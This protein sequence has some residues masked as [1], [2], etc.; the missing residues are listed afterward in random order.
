MDL[1][2]WGIQSIVHQVKRCPR[3]MCWTFTTVL[4]QW[5]RGW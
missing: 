2:H 3:E 1:K 5:P 4:T